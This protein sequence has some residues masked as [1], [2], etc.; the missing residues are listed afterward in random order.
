ME[1][2]GGVRRTVRHW[3]GEP[4]GRNSL[5]GSN[6]VPSAMNKKS[7]TEI[8]KKLI[9]EIETLKDEKGVILAG[10]P[11]YA[12]F[13]GRD[14]LV[15]SWQLLP[16]Q[17]EICRQTL[18]TLSTLQGKKINTK[19]E[20]EPGKIVHETHWKLKRHPH[21]KGFPFPYYGSV[22]STPLFG[23]VFSLYIQ[24]TKD[25]KFL[26]K[27]WKNMKAAIQWMEKYGDTDQDLFLEYKRKNPRGLFHQGWKDGFQNHLKIRPPVSLV[28]AQ[29][30][31]YLASKNAAL[32][33]KILKENNFAK[34]LLERAKK[35]KKKFNEKFW[36]EKEGYF[37]LA[38]DGKK[39]QKRTIT[40]NPGHLLF[41]GIIEKEKEKKVVKRLF[42]KDL[43]TPFGIRTH[44]TKDPHFDPLSYHRGTVWPHDNWIIAQGLKKLGYKK[45]YRKIKNAILK[46]YLE[47][48]YLPELYGVMGK[49]II[50]Y[51]GA[52]YPQ[53]WASGALLNFLTLR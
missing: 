20:E 25:Q 3:F 39:N 47:L 44:S 49:K 28:E 7:I 21:I 11:H 27:Y 51:K 45:E 4:A 43:W 34:R 6:P 41:T 52:C 26:R 33:A 31:Q 19:N 16:F 29:G 1:D 35:L 12:R 42:Q 37:A 46:A 13:F 10:F 50:E 18:K 38:L 36:I 24:K 48:G 14:S 53:A 22:D 9:S 15:T 32:L 17:P 8:K 23:I 2:K 5:A 40:S 30:Y